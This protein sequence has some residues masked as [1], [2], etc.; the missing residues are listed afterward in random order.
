MCLLHVQELIWWMSLTFTDKENLKCEVSEMHEYLN[1]WFQ[2]DTSAPLIK[3]CTSALPCIQSLGSVFIG[4][5]SWGSLSF[6]GVFDISDQAI[7]LCFFF[8]VTWQ[9]SQISSSQ[10]PSLSFSCEFSSECLPLT[11]HVASFV[12][13]AGEREGSNTR[14]NGKTWRRR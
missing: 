8:F 13:S 7:C 4:I 6:C 5:S 14:W 1:Q 2:K 10:P 9:F 11:C 3:Y 12:N